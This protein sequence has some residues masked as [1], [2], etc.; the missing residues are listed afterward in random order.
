MT[1]TQCKQELILHGLCMIGTVPSCN[2]LNCYV[3][4][5][6]K[7]A[8]NTQNYSETWSRACSTISH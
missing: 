3:S 8:N 2:F 1:R 7:G 5:I 4:F 6:L